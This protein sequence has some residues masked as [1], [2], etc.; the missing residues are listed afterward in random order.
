M[1]F[2][3]EDFDGSLAGGVEYGRGTPGAVYVLTDVRT[4][5]EAKKWACDALREWAY[6]GRNDYFYQIAHKWAER[7]KYDGALSLGLTLDFLYFFTKHDHSPK[8]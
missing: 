1:N 6:A 7:Y 2:V 5:D 8:S 3:V 4:M